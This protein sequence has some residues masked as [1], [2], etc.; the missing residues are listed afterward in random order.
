VPIAGAFLTVLL[1]LRGV[2][3]H[4]GF[5]VYRDLFPGQLH[6][7]YLWHPQ[8]SFLA[9]ENYKFVTF[10]GP[11][12]PFRALGPEVYEK[13]VYAAAVAVA[14]I[15]LYVAAYRLLGQLRGRTFS[16]PVRHAASLLA[17][18]TYVAN[19]A[20][21]N[22]LC[23]FSLFVGYAFAPLWLVIFMEMLAGTRR[24]G[25]AVILVAL[26]WWL[27][28]IKAH[29]I[30]FGALSL[31]PPLVA[32]GVRHRG[33]L[34]L[35]LWRGNLV[36]TIVITLLYLLASAYWLIPFV[37]ASG[38]R[39]VGS[40]APMTYETVA[41]LSHAPWRDTVRLLG[42]LQAW[43]YIPFAPPTPVLSIP[44][45]LASWAIPA[46]A[47][48]AILW[49]RRHWQIWALVLFA[50]VGIVLTKGVAPPLGGLYTA[51]VFGDLT[52]PA[53][54]WLFR[55][56]S[57]WNVFLSL[58]YSWLVAFALAELL[59]RID[60][61]R[62][63]RVRH[64]QPGSRAL[65]AVAAYLIALPLFAW[66][67]FSGD[68]NG[69]LSPVHLPDALTQ[70][71][72]WLAGQ[73]ADFK[74][75]WIPVTNGRELSWN[76]RPSGDLYTSLSA[77]PSIGT[78][79][80]RHPVLFYSYAYD[81]LANDRILNFGKLLSFLNT[82]YVAYHDDIETSH[83][84]TGV[85]PVAVLIE[86]GEEALTTQLNA[87]QDMRLAWEQDFVSIYET[88]DAALPLFVPERLFLS[89]A[90]LTVLTSL[91][92]LQQFQPAREGIL[93]DGSREAGTFPAQVDG[94]ILGHD[95]ADHLAFAMLP[96]ER[97]ISP[98]GATLHSDVAQDWSRLDIYQFDWQMLLR[99]YGLYYWGFDYGQGMVAHASDLHGATQG[100]TSPSRP[101]LRIPV[102][103]PASGQ[104][105]LWVRYLRHARAPEIRLSV[106][107]GPQRVLTG[108]DP[109]TRFVWEMAATVELAAGEHIVTLE[110]R[111]GLSAI[112]ALA[113]LSEAEMADLRARAGAL[114]AAVP[115]IYM[116]EA[117]ADFDVAGA[118][119][120]PQT[121]VLSAGRGVA[122]G[123]R[124]AISTTLDL[125]APG[126]YTVAVRASLT[127]ESGT[128]TATLGT[129]PGV[130]FPPVQDATRGELEWL[131]A[132]PIHLDA[133]TVP[134]RLE[135]SES[136]VLDA[137]M[138]Y[139]HSAA[140]AP[141]ALFQPG[142]PPAEISYTQIDPTR[143]RVRVRAEHPFM[144]ALAETYD[145]LWVAR[146]PD[147]QV[148]SVPLF[149]VVN[150]FYLDR[151]GSYELT[152][153]YQPQQGARLGAVFSTVVV[154]GLVPLLWLTWR[155]R[156]EA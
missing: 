153:E 113:L 39:F 154:M 133:G 150:G 42:L 95:A 1:L 65:L 7:P 47:V 151:T 107:G 19:P 68:F 14:F 108:Q 104:Y 22:I 86:S 51:L 72:A 96:A 118:D 34:H 70:A 155:G 145:P 44:W 90:D 141:E 132:G 3:F 88:S 105:Q 74:A 67:A 64:D 143:Y 83:I 24:R 147:L 80:N 45:T 4:P 99:D 5:V 110:N 100:T 10:T 119:P 17:A 114:A 109:V 77:K 131:T 25:P 6:Y 146:G 136:A 125:A 76:P 127:A 66:P 97:I 35:Q 12:L 20:A 28:A 54:R 26:L 57:K 78:N 43:P 92:A 111:A 139:T 2:L 18:L 129:S 144:L 130:Q 48:A 62:W 63:R 134:I 50:A 37:Q 122:L 106:D 69:A 52:P 56:S 102:H 60:W 40:T 79:W 156:R 138:L 59:S 142:T 140:P 27:S 75:H 46:L 82:R 135:A 36:S 16:A 116:L 73:E 41:Y 152:I 55:V 58:G 30:L 49:F 137:F 120:A 121:K 126:D 98:A 8:G 115:N 15:A 94:L 148:S 101:V 31:V 29:W 23:D 84:H 71:N 85:E 87:Q 9:L 13:V 21:A 33:R 38:E 89:T 11:F 61:H 93:F 112:N 123:A 81:A 117:E 53:F 32:W 91:G 128:L 149:G 124:A 103:A